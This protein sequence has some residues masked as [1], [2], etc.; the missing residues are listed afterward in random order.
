MHLTKN[1]FFVKKILFCFSAMLRCW[2]ARTAQG[3]FERR[4]SAL[5]IRLASAA[6]TL[7]LALQ[8]HIV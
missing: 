8:Q 2:D 5:V 3:L 6:C 4:Q 7:Q 1:A